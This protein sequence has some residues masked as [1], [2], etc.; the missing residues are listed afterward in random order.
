M[1]IGEA[2]ESLGVK[3]LTG[4]LKLVISKNSINSTSED[5]S[6]ENTD[7]QGTITWNKPSTAISR[8]RSQLKRR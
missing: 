3:N 7:T 8:P 4:G 5:A 2:K 1:K 6:I